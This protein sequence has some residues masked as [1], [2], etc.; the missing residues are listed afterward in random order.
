MANT[1]KHYAEDEK[2][3]GKKNKIFYP[4]WRGVI[5]SY[6]NESKKSNPE[7]FNP[8]F[9]GFQKMFD[10]LD[11]VENVIQERNPVNLMKFLSDANGPYEPQLSYEDAYRKFK[12]I[13]VRDNEFYA[14]FDL[15]GFKHKEVD[16][17]IQEILG[18]A[19]EDFNLQAMAGFDPAN[20][21]FHKRD[22]NHVMRW[23]SI[24]YFT[25]TLGLFRWKSLEDQYRVRFRVGLDKSGHKHLRERKYVALEK[26]CFMFYDRCSDGIVK[27]IYHFDKWI[28][29]QQEDFDFVRPGWIGCRNRQTILNNFIYLLNAYI[30]GVPIQYVL[31]LHER[32]KHDRNKAITHSLNEQMASIGLNSVLDEHHVAD[33]FA[34]TIRKNIANSANLVDFRAANDLVTVNSDL[35]AV[36]MAKTL[37]LLPIPESLQRVILGGIT[38]V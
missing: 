2:L 21:L 36:A 14:V 37:G 1:D 3:S 27:P 29:F 23:A 31:L 16:P 13:S 19:P 5:T 22:N 18:L 7:E 33:C 30:I 26:L 24:G 6:I 12:G 17:A 28:V 35:E 4:T 11:L 10:R 32:Q 38:V 8:G 20:P 34:K 15:Y 25:Y 9:I